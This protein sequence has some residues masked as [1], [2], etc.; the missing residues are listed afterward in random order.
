MNEIIF[1]GY[2]LENEVKYKRVVDGTL[3]KEGQLDGG[4]GLKKDDDGNITNG[5]QILAEYDRLG[6][7]ITKDGEK[8]A[9]GS[10]YDFKNR[11][12]RKVPD[13]QMEEKTIL[14]AVTVETV[15]DKGPVKP[16]TRVRRK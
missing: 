8:V 3:G 1:D 7:L 10:F 16:K 11:C 9:T 2:K 5:A 13:V 6:G 14:P 12:A 4:I 15:D